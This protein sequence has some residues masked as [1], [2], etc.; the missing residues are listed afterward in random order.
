MTSPMLIK[1]SNSKFASI[2]LRESS[3]AF[4]ITLFVLIVKIRYKSANSIVHRKR[5]M[6]GFELTVQV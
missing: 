4:K 2:F 1:A 6:K 5:S 3:L